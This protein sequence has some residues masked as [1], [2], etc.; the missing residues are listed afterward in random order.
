MRDSKHP[1]PTEGT[2]PRLPFEV[3]IHRGQRAIAAAPP[4]DEESDALARSAEAPSPAALRK[5]RARQRLRRALGGLGLGLLL[6]LGLAWWLARPPPGTLARVNGEPITA[7]MLDREIL[8]NRTL[9][10]L[11][12]DGAGVAATRAATLER[13]IS[14]RMQAQAAERAGGTVT[15]ADLDV[16]IARLAAAQ[17]WSAAQLDAA[18]AR[19]G[20]SRADLRAGLR[21]PVLVTR[22]VNEVV[23]KNA[24]DTNH[25]RALENT[26]FGQ[27]QRTTSIE[28]LGD[29]DSEAAPRPGASAPDF[30]LQDL[31]GQPVRL[32]DLRGRP[33]L[34]NFWATWCQP[35]R[36]EMPVL[37]SA[38][39]QAHATTPDSQGLALLAVATNS[40]PDTVVAFNKEFAMPFSV[41]IDADNQVTN[42]YRIGPIP[43]SYLVDRQGV[44]RWVHVGV[45]TDA[46]LREKLQLIP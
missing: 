42:R 28:R 18:L 36:I 30:T 13:L 40:A 43:T 24:R 33:V 26:W 37:V 32:A 10:E 5:A 44:I 6:A 22:Y 46:L 17:Q 11:A 29:P 35:C 12:N 20:L 19:Q 23:T 34:I 21:D 14:L 39:R 9:S 27:V 25:A 31:Q 7:A 15:E 2:P 45:W 16:A 41:L 4:A 38:Y 1:A 8:L 3:Q